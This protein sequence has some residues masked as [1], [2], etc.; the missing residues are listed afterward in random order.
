[1][2]KETRKTAL[3]KIRT[4]PVGRREGEREKESERMREIAQKRWRLRKK[5]WKE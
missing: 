3:R 2:A 1:M 5:K 4:S